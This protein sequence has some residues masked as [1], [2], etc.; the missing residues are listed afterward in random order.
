MG[1]KMV[2]KK[3]DLAEKAG[4][5]PQWLS[6]VLA[7]RGRPAWLLCEKLGSLTGSDPVIWARMDTAAMEAA[8]DRWMKGEGEKA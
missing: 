4:V 5:S 8:V 7:G 2:R 6:T 1:K 3:K